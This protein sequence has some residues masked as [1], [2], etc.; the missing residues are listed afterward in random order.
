M[1]AS[2]D[3]VYRMNPDWSQVRRLKGPG[4]ADGADESIDTLL[5]RDIP[6]RDR[7]TVRAAIAEAISSRSL[8]DLE[9]RTLGPD[10]TLGWTHSRAVPILSDEG[11]IKEWLGSSTDVT[12]MK[13]EAI[14]RARAEEALRESEGRLSQFGEASQDVLWIRD[15]RTFQWLYLT[16]AF[17]VIYG[18]DRTT[19]FSGD[20]MI[21][22]M[23]RILPEDRDRALACLERVR[24]GE[25]VTFEYRIRKG[26][27]GEIRWL[28]DT[29]FPMRD[30][31]GTVCWIGGIGRDMTEEKRTAEHMTLLVGELQH[32]TRNLMGIVRIMADKTMEHAT[33]LAD[34]NERYTKRLSA[35]ARVQGLLSR[36][37]G[38]RRIT[39][40]ELIR[41]EIDALGDRGSRITLE[42]PGGVAL[43]SGAVQIFALA[44]HELATNAAKYGAFSQPHGQLAVRWRV[45]RPIPGG[46]PWLHVDWR[47]RGVVMPAP[48]TAHRTGE[49]GAGRELIERALPYQIGAR[50]SFALGPDGVHCTISLPVSRQQTS[51]E[52]P[53]A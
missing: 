22:W 11:K 51:E 39:F 2:S 18:L 8:F 31:A 10:G 49:T 15:A 7:E 48:G 50:T 42:G 44:L 34:F 21:G 45:D 47:E 16:P 46:E 6:P 23:E 37:K 27:D 52:K 1:T 29:D 12:A 32:R 30:A 35:L 3:V 53:D 24:A 40:G 25:R 33:G 19:A 17:E 9:H 14:A 26:S 20:N 13:E 36:L 43:R 41:S 28:R 4:Q 38:N 5:E